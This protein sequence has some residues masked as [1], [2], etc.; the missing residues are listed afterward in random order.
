L[1]LDFLCVGCSVLAIGHELL[2]I[3]RSRPSQ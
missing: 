1:R 3:Y 2:Q